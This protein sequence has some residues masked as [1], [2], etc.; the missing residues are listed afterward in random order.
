[1]A[2]HVADEGDCCAHWFGGVAVLCYLFQLIAEFD[3]LNRKISLSDK[4][5]NIA[6]HP[7]AL[8]FVPPGAQEGVLNL[9]LEIVND[10]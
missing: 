1:M 7:N 5:K 6:R 8:Q 9:V 3:E 2:G 4:W 10:H